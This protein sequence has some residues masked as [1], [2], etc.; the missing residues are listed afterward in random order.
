MDVR[1]PDGTVIKGVP[2]GMTRAELTA[3]LKA[4]GIGINPAAQMPAMDPT[5]G[6]ST[7][8]K[9]AAGAG[10]AVSDTGLGLGQWLGLVDRADVAE[11]RLRDAPLMATGAGTVGNIAGNVA[12]LAPTALVPGAN[13]LTGAGLIG[14]LTGAAQPSEGTPETLANI[15]FGGAGGV[16]GQKLANMAGGY[17]SRKAAENA[18]NQLQ[19]SQTAAAAKSAMDAGYVIPPA[20]LD[21]RGVTQFVSGLSGKIKTAQ[22][23]SARNQP[24]TNALVRKELGI[25]PDVPLNVDT[26]NGIRSTAGRA[27]DAVASTG[28]V[29]PG[30]AYDSALD[31]IVAPFK[32]AAAGFPNAKPNPVMAEI[33]ALRSNAFDAGSAIAQIRELR[34]AADAAYASRNASAGRAYKGAAKALEDAIDAHLVANNA[35]A[36]LLSGYREARKLIAKTYTVQKALN[37]ETGDVSAQVLGRELSKGRPLSGDIRTAAQ[38]GAAF[39]KATQAL[40]ETPKTL[41]PLDFATAGLGLVGSGG[42]PLAA[43]GLVARPAARA[44]LLSG[45]AQ[46]MALEQAGALATP[47]LL[48]RL[49]QNEPATLPLGVLSGLG[50]ANALS[51]YLAQK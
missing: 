14:A 47:N 50:G 36:D 51:A 15:G 19:R 12:M 42:N 3:K 2:D 20:D 32:T 5:E 29:Q 23:A 35:P 1:L 37:S 49:L 9:L 31:R 17:V 40:K 4:N 8:D 13:T 38:A 10:K 11:S 22:E 16:A 28:T 7:L 43:A 34:D 26:L 46:R 25:A 24:V 44:A 21:R 18:A 33:E 30:Q 41:S 39:P 6:M 45:P 27:Y 48:A